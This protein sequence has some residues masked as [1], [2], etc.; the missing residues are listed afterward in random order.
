[1]LERDC[2]KLSGVQIL[3]M[4]TQHNKNS[5][6]LA[7][8]EKA[9]PDI[10]SVRNFQGRGFKLS[11]LGFKISITQIDEKNLGKLHVQG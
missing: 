8:G 11:N 4:K 10:A 9:G 7:V 5:R 2:P 1:M 3:Q 6:R